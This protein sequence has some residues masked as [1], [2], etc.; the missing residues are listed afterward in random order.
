ML[1]FTTA[2]E[3]ALFGKYSYGKNLEALRV[4]ISKCNCQQK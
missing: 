2:M 1:Y 3:K 4:L